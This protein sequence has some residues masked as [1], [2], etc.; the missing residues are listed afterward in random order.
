MMKTAVC[1]CCGSVVDH[2]VLTDEIEVAELIDHTGFRR[3][4]AVLFLLMFK[5]A[6]RTV[7]KTTL[8][9]A[10]EVA[11]Q[12]CEMTEGA[13]RSTVQYLNREM[14]GMPVR[15]V[16]VYGVGYRLEKSDPDWHWQKLPLVSANKARI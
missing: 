6:G 1:P 12:G 11:R 3:Q 7:T 8:M 9:D 13:L 16:P 2:K 4:T 15:V 10:I 5:C 14:R